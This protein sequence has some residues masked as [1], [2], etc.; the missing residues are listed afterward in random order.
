MVIDKVE[1]IL[2]GYDSVTDLSRTIGGFARHLDFTF[3]VRDLDVVR[4]GFDE[5]HDDGSRVI[6]VHKGN[7]YSQVVVSVDA[8]PWEIAEKIA[9][10]AF[11]A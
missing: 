10:E 2:A 8:E 11:Y 5:Y 4:M 3:H 7:S 6:V 1:K 9:T